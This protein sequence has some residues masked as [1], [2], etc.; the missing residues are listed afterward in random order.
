M[1]LRCRE[2]SGT[3]CH[4]WVWQ[5]VGVFWSSSSPR[6][7]HYHSYCWYRRRGHRNGL[8][9]EEAHQDNVCKHTKENESVFHYVDVCPPE[10]SVASEGD[11]KANVYL[12]LEVMLSLSS[13]LL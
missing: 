1:Q 8:C 12:S 9:T 11:I 4:L 3:S 2:D 6:C 5:E 7:S 10:L 13:S